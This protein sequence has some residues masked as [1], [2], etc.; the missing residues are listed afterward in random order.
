MVSD[1]QNPDFEGGQ[2]VL[3]TYIYPP[4]SQGIGGNLGF[5]DSLPHLAESIPTSVP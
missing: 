5:A 1:S 2:R 3:G 4:K